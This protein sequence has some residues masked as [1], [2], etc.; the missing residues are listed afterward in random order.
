MALIEIKH[1]TKRFGE[2]TILDDVSL[3]IEQGDAYGILGLSGAGKSTLLRSINGLETIDD[4]EIYFDGELLASPSHQ[5]ER[6][7]RQQIAVIF[8]SFNLLNQATALQNVELAL[9]IKKAENKKEKA[10]EA[11]RLVGLEH[12]ANSYPSQL[13]GGEKQRV[14][15]AR[16]IALEPKVLLSDEAT[17]ALDAENAES[18]ISLLADLNKRLGL[19]VIMVSH[20]IE[21]VQKFCSKV[22]IIDKAKIVEKGELK[23]VFLKPQSEIARSLIYSGREKYRSDVDAVR[24]LFEGNTDTP[25]VA[26]IVKDLDLLLSVLYADTKVIEG[27]IYGQ[28]LLEAPKT[29]EDRMRLREYLSAKGIANEEV[30]HD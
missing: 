1:V 5:V 20:Q 26:A 19:T 15:I 25:I 23:E 4:G 17:S 18:V 12:K 16:A 24:L 21:V 22:A 13:S 27:K 29:K 2:K 7:K 14:A 11:L 9:R 3:E 30:H 8:Q 10:L 6:K 28:L